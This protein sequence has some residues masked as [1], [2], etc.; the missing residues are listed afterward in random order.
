LGGLR[1][2][3]GAIRKT[4][5]E[6]LADLFPSGANGAPAKEISEVADRIEGTILE[7]IEEKAEEE[8]DSLREETTRPKE[9]P[10]APLD[11]SEPM[12]DEGPAPEEAEEPEEAP[13]PEEDM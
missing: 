6:A 10:A 5:Q 12:F 8:L 1:A 11:F 4:A 3:K 2:L 9:A 13:E 7:I